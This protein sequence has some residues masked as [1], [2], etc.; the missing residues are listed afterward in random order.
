MFGALGI[1]PSLQ[2]CPSRLWTSCRSCLPLK[3][4]WIPSDVHNGSRSFLYLGLW[5]APLI[6][7]CSGFLPTKCQISLASFPSSACA[8]VCGAVRSTDNSENAKDVSIAK[9][10]WIKFNSMHKTCQE[11]FTGSNL[12]PVCLLWMANS[13]PWSNFHRLITMGCMVW[14][15]TL[16]ICSDFSS[17]VAADLPFGRLFPLPCMHRGA[18]SMASSRAYYSITGLNSTTFHSLIAHWR[19]LCRIAQFANNIKLFF[20]WHPNKNSAKNLLSC[21]VKNFNKVS[22]IL[23]SQSSPYLKVLSSPSF[24]WLVF[25][26]FRLSDHQNITHCPLELGFVTAHG[27]WPGTGKHSTDNLTELNYFRKRTLHFSD[28]FIDLI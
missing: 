1:L 23:K 9:T 25:R 12:L 13:F 27:K 3:M 26:C 7:M 22:V 4:F 17:R 14:P 21:S 19:Y 20:S 24:W 18:C 28:T 5:I 8:S 6:F 10:S 16:A 11:I 2:L 15:F